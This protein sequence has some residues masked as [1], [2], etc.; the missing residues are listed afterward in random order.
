V[1]PYD[2]I[3]RLHLL[4]PMQIIVYILLYLAPSNSY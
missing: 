1:L 2:F 4:I 3:L